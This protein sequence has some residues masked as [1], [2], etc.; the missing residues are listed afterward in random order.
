MHKLWLFG[1]HVLLLFLL[2]PLL[3][4]FLLIVRVLP[5]DLDQRV[6]VRRFELWLPRHVCILVGPTS[7]NLALAHELALHPCSLLLLALE[8]RPELIARLI[9]RGFA[10]VLV[11]V[12]LMVLLPAPILVERR[13]H[14]LLRAHA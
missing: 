12:R 8:L 5:A 11:L 1:S 7:P 4:L 14:H 13:S 2:E 3:L 10:V 9:G 6:R